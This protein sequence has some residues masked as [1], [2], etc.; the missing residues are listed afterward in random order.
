MSQSASSETKKLK[1]SKALKKFHYDWMKQ[2]PWFRYDKELNL[3]YCHLCETA[4]K[5]NAMALGT[6]HFRTSTMTRHVE[7]PDHKLVM[8]GLVMQTSIERAFSKSVDNETAAVTTAMKAVYYIAKEHLPLVKYP[9]LINLFRNVKADSISY[10]TAG[11][12]M[13]YDTTYAA[14]EF[15]D[16]INE[17]LVEETNSKLKE[18]TCISIMCDES[19]DIALHKKL[20]IWARVINGNVLPEPESLYLTDLKIEEGTGVAVSKAIF[21]H[22]EE[23]GVDLSKVSGLGTDGATV[24]TD[25]DKGVTGQFLQ[26]NPH[27]LN[28]HCSAHRVALVT[29]Q[30]SDGFPVL[31]DFQQTL[32]DLFYYFHK[33]SQRT[34]NLEN[35]QKILDA[36][37][38]KV[39]EIHQVRWLSFFEAFSNIYKSLPAL[40]MYFDSIRKQKDPKG[41][42]IG[43]KVA[44]Y[45][46][47]YLTSMMLDVLAP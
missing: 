20:A 41:E 32:T 8:Q 3:M 23:R 36:P 45:K 21:K 35:V 17:C 11:E 26:L 22:L 6:D 29:S 10:L 38:L 37:I 9:S 5:D 4:K 30:A 34:Q 43:Q 39:K 25:K 33:S 7:H 13:K 12:S 2:W 31:K 16:A 44:S 1:P 24:M 28:I 27:I 15:L 46:F 47:V 14:N 18:A 19:T 40:I 42:G